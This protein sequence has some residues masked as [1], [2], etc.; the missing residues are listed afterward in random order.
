MEVFLSKSVDRGM[1]LVRFSDDL[2]RVAV[3]Y[4]A[5]NLFD[6]FSRNSL[7]FDFTQIMFMMTQKCCLDFDFIFVLPSVSDKDAEAKFGE[8]EKRFA[9][10]RLVEDGDIPKL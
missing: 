7:C 4:C 3:F 2:N 8:F 10:L 9:Y 1:I 6:N 5:I